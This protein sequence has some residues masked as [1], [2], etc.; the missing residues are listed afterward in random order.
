MSFINANNFK[1]FEKEQS[2]NVSFFIDPQTGLQIMKMS[3][4]AKKNSRLE[5]NPKKSDL[6]KRK[7]IIEVLHLLDNFPLT[8]TRKK[9]LKI[10]L[11]TDLSEGITKFSNN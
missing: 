5:R 9:I 4:Q 2:E 8:A 10:W 7:K 6:D 11:S 3:E 1:K